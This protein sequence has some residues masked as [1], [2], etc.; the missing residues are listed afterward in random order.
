MKGKSQ[1]CVFFYREVT[2]Q[3]LFSAFIYVKTMWSFPL[4]ILQ[5]HVL[6]FRGAVTRVLRYWREIKCAGFLTVK[7]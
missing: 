5:Q 4:Y 1:E 2:C 7:G 3:F 6:G